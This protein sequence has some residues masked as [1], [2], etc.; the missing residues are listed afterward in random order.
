M[1]TYG[2]CQPFALPIHMNFS[3]SFFENICYRDLIF[4]GWKKQKP[5]LEIFITK[6]PVITINR[7]TTI[8]H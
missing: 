2:L 5:R 6:E 1:K 4:D 7:I 8:S 3:L